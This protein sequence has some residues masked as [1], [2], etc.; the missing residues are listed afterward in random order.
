[1]PPSPSLIEKYQRILQADPRSRIFVEL[2]RQ[3]FDAGAPERAA[4]VCAR[5]LEHHPSSVQGRVIW[6]K[7]LLAL[8]R[9]DEALAR[10]Q[11]AIDADPDNPYGYDL[12]GEV[13]VGAGLSGRARPLLEKGAAL[14]PGDGRIRKWL[15]E[16]KRAAPEAQNEEDIVVVDG[17]EPGTAAPLPDPLPTA[18]AEGEAIEAAPSG[19]TPSV[20]E[21]EV[22]TSTPEAV[23]SAHSLAGASEPPASLS[24]QSEALPPTPPKNPIPTDDPFATALQAAADAATP[25]PSAAGTPSGSLLLTPPPLKSD[26]RRSKAATAD[27]APDPS[28]VLALI[29]EAPAT[30]K[31][32][33]ETRPADGPRQVATATGDEES[34]ASAAARTYEHELR[35]KF[36]AESPPRPSF[37]RRHA[38]GAALVGV[39]LA[40]AAGVSIYLAVR[41][42]RRAVEA[43]AA[44]DAARKGLARDTLGAL[45]EAERVLA[46]A[47]RVAPASAEAAAVEAEVAGLL[48]RDFGDQAARARVRELLASGSAGAGASAARWLVA[49]GQGESAAADA[50]LDE[51]TR[52]TPLARALAGE[53]LLARRDRDGARV[54]LEA[55]AHATPPLLRALAALGD[56]EL[57]RGDPGAA[58]DRYS[59][60]LRAHPTHP[61]AAIGAAEARL[62]L[63]RDLP[64]ALRV[65]EAVDAA[66]DSAPALRDR[67]RMD[68]LMARLLA[69][70]GRAAEA[71]RRL[72]DAAARNPAHADVAAAQAEVFAH[73]GDLDHAI[74][75]AEG[76]VRLAPGDATYRELLVRLQLRRGLY[77]EL[78][79]SSE[80][81]P[82]RTLRLYR[83]IA[84][85]ELGQPVLALA[86]LEGTRRDG[87]M[88]AED[89]GWMA[90]AHIAAG[91]RPQAAVIVAALLAAPTPHAVALLA[92][93]R[94]DLASGQADAAERRF[95]EAVDRDPDLIDARCDLGRVLLARGRTAEARDVLEK[96]VARNPHDLQ[97]RFELGRARL[98][99]G[100][101]GGAVRALEAVRAERPQDPAVLVTSSSAQLAAGNPAEARRLAERA[102]EIAP[103]S[104]AA[105]LAAGKAA[106]AQGATRDA[107]GLLER[108]AKL[109]GKGPEAADARRAL[110]SLRR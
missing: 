10:F 17:A 90:L 72:R 49:D 15:A 36:L 85:F 69:V 88:T 65:L 19:A 81:A 42:S 63:G 105:A 38:L 71:E 92:R 6:G 107:R 48:A 70:A 53:I 67:L 43:R 59:L 32:M 41:S 104:A 57:A 50:L 3:L 35:E 46:S 94:L 86:E 18:R 101:A 102:L 9:T 55:A 45:R 64:E 78:L 56:L 103:K 58:L 7:A 108:A 54:H 60:V 47:G 87:K 80:T 77:R 13:L 27:D 4:E 30:Q 26:P 109:G 12:V 11:E 91:H 2:A 99:T 39:A 100:D 82:S 68:L 29:P 24:S 52:G 76:A 21:D 83:G 110:A 62:R 79:A 75:S 61:H 37:L 28:N 5:G 34:E 73:A 74:R 22:P 66:A 51:A 1:M 20:N 40:V 31:P 89:A 84:R 95:R 96:A 16:A 14:H 93:G 98:A 25:N 8:G 23:P 33:A 106:A 44:V 97:A